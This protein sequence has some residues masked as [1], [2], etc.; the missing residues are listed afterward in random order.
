M[1]RQLS[2]RGLRRVMNLWPPY[3][4]A[5]VRV[6]TIAEDWRHAEIELRSH[7]WNRNYVGVHFGGNLFSMTDPFWMLLTLNA[8]GKDYIVWDKAG[9]IDFRKPGHGTVRAHFRLDDAMLDEIRAATAG[10]DKYL[11]WCETEIVDADGE[12]VARVR[13]QLYIRRKESAAPSA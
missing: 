12:V 7:W 5:G 3:L 9:A 13:K 4:F 11:R 1:P 2:A 10:G 8:L 6:R